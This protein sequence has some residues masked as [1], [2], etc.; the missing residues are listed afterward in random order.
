MIVCTYYFNELSYFTRS[1]PDHLNTMSGLSDMITDAL[2]ITGKSSLSV[3]G[4]EMKTITSKNI[5]FD[6][7]IDQSGRFDKGVYEVP[8][9]NNKSYITT[10]NTYNIFNSAGN[11]LSSFND[12][13]NGSSVNIISNNTYYKYTFGIEFLCF[14]E[15][16][17]LN[18]KLSLDTK[19]Y[20]LLSELFYIDRENK[21]RYITILNN[22]KTS[23]NLDEF[24]VPNNDYTLLFDNI[25]VNKLYLPEDRLNTELSL[26]KVSIKK[27]E[28]A[29]EGELILGPSNLSTT[30]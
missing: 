7:D 28:F 15:I 20:P 24:R 1:L 13:L 27:M 3:G 23:I 6:K 26:D 25:T 19:S 9:K 22:Y 5:T 21:R 30:Y 8:Y 11:S 29:E 16:N 10:E 14:L 4:S 2:V 17:S 18:L 12:L